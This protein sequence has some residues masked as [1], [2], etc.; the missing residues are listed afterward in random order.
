MLAHSKHELLRRT[1]PLSGVMRTSE[2]ALQM[3]AYD[4]NR[5]WL[6][7]CKMSRLTHLRHHAPRPKAPPVRFITGRERS[8]TRIATYKAKFTESGR[9]QGSKHG[10]DMILVYRASIP[11]H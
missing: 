10:N 9:A 1:C 3:S 11:S 6:V 5:T 4:P 8:P 7:Q 2:F